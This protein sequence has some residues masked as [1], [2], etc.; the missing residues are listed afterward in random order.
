MQLVKYHIHF[1]AG[2]DMEHEKRQMACMGMQGQGHRGQEEWE[3]L[4]RKHGHLDFEQDMEHIDIGLG[5]LS[6]NKPLSTV[7]PVNIYIYTEKKLLLI[8]TPG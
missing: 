3:G 1:E 4:R 6:S 2:R 5:V 8:C 7:I